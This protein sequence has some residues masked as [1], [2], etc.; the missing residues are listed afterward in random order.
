MAVIL[1]SLTLTILTSRKLI[2]DKTKEETLNNIYD[3]YELTYREVLKQLKEE[4]ISYATENDI[5]KES[6]KIDDFNTSVS[7]EMI[8]A[9]KLNNKY[10]TVVSNNSKYDVYLGEKETITGNNKEVENLIDII[11]YKIEGNSYQQTYTGKNL[12]DVNSI[13]GSSISINGFDVNV[14]ILTLNSS[15][16]AGVTLRE[17]CPSLI[18]GETYTISYTTL[19][20][21]S[22]I[23]IGS[24][25]TD[26][27][28]MS[29]TSKTITETDL[30][31]IVRM[32]RAG[33]GGSTITFSNIQVELGTKATEYE[34]Y[35]GG[36][37]SPNPQYPQEVYS[38]GDKITD[39]TDSNSG[40]YNITIRTGSKNLL[41]NASL[42][43]E[44]TS[45]AK[46][47]ITETGFK[48]RKATSGGY[49][50]TVIYDITDIVKPNTKYYFHRELDKNYVSTISTQDSIS[51]SLTLLVDG[52]QKARIHSNPV[53]V[54]TYFTMPETFESV[55]IA[56]WTVVGD[57]QTENFDSNTE[58]YLEW[59]NLYM[60]TEPYTEYVPY[61]KP[62]TTNIYLDNPL[63]KLDTYKDYIDYSEKS[64]VRNTKEYVI[65]GNEGET[66]G[67]DW[68]YSGA[69]GHEIRSN[70]L[71]NSGIPM[72]QLA[73][74]NYY[75]YMDSKNAKLD[76]IRLVTDTSSYGYIAINDLNYPGTDY[77]DSFVAHLKELYNNGVPVKVLYPV[78]P[79]RNTSSLDLP[80][81]NTDIGTQTISIDTDI[82]PSNVEFTVIKKIKQL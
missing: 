44:D 26:N 78:Y 74:S 9:Y 35:V 4:I 75:P 3:R 76:H 10:L 43:V 58:Y 41:D 64:V 51:G 19:L 36:K 29:G 37:S 81:I 33:S 47:E 40:K 48:Q 18:V 8:N 72:K 82:A 49:V 30:D 65:T 15:S 68:K 62:Y 57:A 20:E 23:S 31:S 2:I 39:D 32:G 53:Q 59:S 16:S 69:Y 7:E 27:L 11:D 63:R 71:K 12:F 34:P 21:D 60:G 45:N 13:T 54:N 66:L 55:Q 70:I 79:D 17:L 61:V 52:V 73:Q 5:T 1:V 24:Y 22:Y 25:A 14:E 67:I 28:W 77:V 38:V 6:I 46:W 42:V 50:A 80:K 56:T